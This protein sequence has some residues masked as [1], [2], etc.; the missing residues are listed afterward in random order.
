MSQTEVKEDFLEVDTP[1][2]GQNFVCISFV[3]PEK[4]LAK[5]ETFNVHRFLQENAEKYGLDQGTITEQYDD[6]CYQNREKLEKDF[7]EQNDFRTTVR[8]VKV[9][10]VYD[11]YR[12]AEV[13]AKLLQRKDTSFHVFVGQ[14]GY[15]LP[16]DPCADDIEDQEYTEKH[17]NKLVKK[18]KDNQKKKEEYF[19][20]QKEESVNKM[21]QEN[22]AQRAKLEAEQQ[23]AT[24]DLD[25]VEDSTSPGTPTTT[26]KPDSTGES[27]DLTG[28]TSEEV[29]KMIKDSLEDEDPWMKR[30]N[31]SAEGVLDLDQ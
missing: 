4:E 30:K 1:I 7:F 27:L 14:V 28:V 10:G 26:S 8:G 18:Y 19:E 15:W 29:Q 22:E 20:Q 23:E 6:Y 16:W 21:K 5:K 3:S 13:R 11:T 17:L 24:Q 9:R 31:A 12:E 25:Q 2:P